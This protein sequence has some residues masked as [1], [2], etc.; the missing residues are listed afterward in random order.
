LG[1][2]WK[3]SW[4]AK[5]EPFLTLLATHNSLAERG[6]KIETE[7]G[8]GDYTLNMRPVYSPRRE[9]IGKVLILSELRQMKTMA[10]R[11]I[12]AKARF[13]F[14]DIY[15][16]NARFL[17]T[18]EQARVISQNNSNVLL[19]GESGTGKD[20]FSQAIH[21]ASPRAAG[22]YVVINCAAIP[23][24]LMA[25]ELFGYAEGAFTGSR[26]GGSPGKFELA[27]GGTI[28]LDEIGEIPIELQAILLRVIEDKSVV[29]IGGS[30]VHPV[31]VRILAA[32]N[33]DLLEEVERGNFR[34]DLYYRL[35]VF[36]L[37][38]LPLSERRDDIPL[39]V[40][41]FIRRYAETLNKP[42]SS[43]DAR[44][45]EYFLTYDWPGNVRELQNVIER[46]MNYARQDV[47]TIDLLPPEM[48]KP[49]KVTCR[50][51]LPLRSPAQE[52][53]EIIEQ[54]IQM[55]YAKKRI[56]ETLGISRATLFRRCRQYGIERTSHHSS[57]P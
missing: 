5:N 16:K 25:S 12:G 40:D 9:L 26:R 1:D 23:H 57:L 38:L 24:N 44:L 37:H 45:W 33:K 4:G 3:R 13:H 49:K 42:V 43:V 46:M 6:V 14:R 20:M 41:T 28:F 18:L 15:G 47:L 19:L 21:N 35:N 56:A 29:R 36:T 55:G 8:I 22:P 2:R 32:T 27:H 54:M 52:E 48:L 50:P 7:A 39:L 31:D 51:S 34:K 10:P 53:Q 17:L 11:M 30:Q